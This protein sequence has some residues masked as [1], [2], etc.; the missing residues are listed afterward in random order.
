MSPWQPTTAASL[1]FCQHDV[2]VLYFLV[3]RRCCVRKEPLYKSSPRRMCYAC[4]LVNRQCWA[5]NTVVQMK[6]KSDINTTHPLLARLSNTACAWTLSWGQ[7]F[8]FM[9]TEHRKNIFFIYSYCGGGRMRPTSM[10][11]GSFL[12][13]YLFV[14]AEAKLGYLFTRFTS[15]NPIWPPRE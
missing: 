12:F 2:A 5:R 10:M 14:E 7:V 1:L 8:W 11:V 4:G 15:Q 6:Y 9:D 3:W 13:I